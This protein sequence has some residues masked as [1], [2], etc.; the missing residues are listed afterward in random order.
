[1]VCM[2][3]GDGYHVQMIAG[4]FCDIRS[5]KLQPLLSAFP[6]LMNT[7]IDEH[8]TSLTG[9]LS[10]CEKEAV[11][12]AGIVH[13]NGNA[14]RRWN[15]CRIGCC[16]GYDLLGRHNISSSARSVRCRLAMGSDLEHCSPLK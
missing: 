13:S 6:L 8:I 12:K 2:L 11:T 7:T 1:M 4:G 5:H 10:E 15:Q 9:H 14:L 16:W 3:M